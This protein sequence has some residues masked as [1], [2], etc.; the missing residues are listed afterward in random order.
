[1]LFPIESLNNS[2]DCIFFNSEISIF[3]NIFCFFAET[4]YFSAVA[5]VHNCSLKYFYDGC[6]HILVDTSNICVIS[7]LI[8]VD[9]LFSFKLRFSWFLV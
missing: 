7:M 4:L 9:Y 2:N 1:M 6:F 5:R 3:L 8:C